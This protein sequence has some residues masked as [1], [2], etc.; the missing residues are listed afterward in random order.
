MKTKKYFTVIRQSEYFNDLQKCDTL[1]IEF[2]Y[3]FVT[4]SVAINY[5]K[6]IE[7]KLISDNVDGFIH[8]A[9]RVTD[10]MERFQ[11]EEIYL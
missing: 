7:E 10:S 4:L 2:V 3:S 11:K 8:Y 1:A 5:I 6:R 9:I